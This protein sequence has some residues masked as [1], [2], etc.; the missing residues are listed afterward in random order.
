MTA[1][2]LDAAAPVRASPCAWPTGASC[3]DV[4]REDLPGGACLGR[5]FTPGRTVWIGS[6]WCTHPR[7]S[8]GLV[9]FLG[10]CRAAGMLAG[11]SPAGHT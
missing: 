1:P 4:D 9:R 6:L 7:K 2:P 5:Q 8:A 10:F 3:A 11:L